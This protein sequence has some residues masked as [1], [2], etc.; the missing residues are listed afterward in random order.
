MKEIG[1]I[2]LLIIT[3]LTCTAC[4]STEEKCDS[5]FDCVKIEDNAYRCNYCK[6]GSKTCS[7]PRGVTCSKDNN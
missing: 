5:S 3:I 4:Q 1:A 2:S 6:D 7:N